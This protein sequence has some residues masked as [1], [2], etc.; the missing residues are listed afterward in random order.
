MCKDR[1]AWPKAD[2]NREINKRQPPTQQTNPRAANPVRPKIT[3]GSVFSF[4]SLV[5]FIKDLTLY[6]GSFT[7]FFA[8]ISGIFGS[9]EASQAK[10]GGPLGVLRNYS[11]KFAQILAGLLLPLLLYLLYLYG[12]YWSMYVSL[13]IVGEA[14]PNPMAPDWYQGFIRWL[15]VKDGGYLPVGREPGVF[16]LVLAVL[17]F[18]LILYL[19]VN[20]NSPHNLYRDRLAHAFMT[21]SNGSDRKADIKSAANMKISELVESAGPFHLVNAALNIQKSAKVNGRGR[22]AGLFTF[23]PSHV[24]SYETGFV[25]TQDLESA[26]WPNF[27]L[28]S[29]MAVSAAAASSA[30]GSQTM[31]PLAATFA[32]LNIRLG[33]WLSNPRWIADKVRKNMQQAIAFRQPAH[34]LSNNSLLLFFREL[35]GWMKEDK[36][37]IYLS[38]GGHIENLG[39]YSLLAR[40]CK[41]IIV[42]DAEAD[43]ELNFSSFVTAQRYA[44]ID[45]GTR[46]EL[47]VDQ[48]RKNHMKVRKEL[49]PKSVLSREKGNQDEAHSVLSDNEQHGP[50]CAL[51]TIFYPDTDGGK[52]QYGVLLYVKAS[53][54]GDEN[55]YVRDYARRYRK[56]PHE[57]TGD[58]FFSEE[59]FEAYRALG[60]HAIHN[61]LTGKD[62]VQSAKGLIRLTDPPVKSGQKKSAAEKPED[63][64]PISL[65]HTLFP[66]FSRSRDI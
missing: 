25:Y 44:R 30:M 21:Y 9:N 33:Y 19:R 58:Q 29:A 45:L 53:L 46:I 16:F 50:H 43:P 59:Q 28:S 36:S 32:L 17:S 37:L 10:P 52:R 8:A 42:V 39:L 47:P 23:S 38:D 24:G 2:K 40:R 63:H 3:I 60:F 22:N 1:E 57:T 54:S 13:P 35:A 64:D 27:T 6:I 11:S 7:A 26:E 51:G 5:S 61:A 18:G 49:D 65:L 12:S 31:R 41:F 56:F 14:V 20:A 48:L 66:G 55:D 62:V 34:L 4:Q 15:E